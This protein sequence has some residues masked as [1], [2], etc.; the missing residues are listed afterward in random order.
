MVAQSAA[1]PA[2]AVFDVAGKPA[3]NENFQVRAHIG[4]HYSIMLREAS[5]IFKERLP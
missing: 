1:K 2:V 3:R 4:A 5:Q